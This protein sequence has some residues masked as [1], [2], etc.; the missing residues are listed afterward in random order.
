METI[1]LDQMPVPEF[2]I[3]CEQKNRLVRLLA[4]EFDQGRSAAHK[5]CARI[6]VEENVSLF[7][8]LR[9]C[10]D[11]DIRLPKPIAGADRLVQRLLVAAHEARIEIIARVASG[12]IEATDQKPSGA[13]KL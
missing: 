9:Q 11:D 3:E 12:T 4:A 8:L 6:A 5:M 13:V 10:P 1:A 7:H 2:R